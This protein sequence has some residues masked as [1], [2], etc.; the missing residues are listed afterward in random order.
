MAMEIKGGVKSAFAPEFFAAMPPLRSSKFLCILA[1]TQYFPGADGKLLS[2]ADPAL[3]FI[4]VRRAHFVSWAR[5]D[6][7][8]ELPEELRKL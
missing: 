1:V 8:V 7:A 3:I 5:G 2:I 6:I 4:D